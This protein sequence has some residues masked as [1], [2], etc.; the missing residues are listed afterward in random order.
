MVKIVNKPNL[1]AS[2]KYFTARSFCVRLRT[3]LDFTAFTGDQIASSSACILF[4][5]AGVFSQVRYVRRNFYS[6]CGRIYYLVSDALAPA[7]HWLHRTSLWTEC[8]RFY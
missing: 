2:D 7:L 8:E 1:L 5:S 4:L 6:P 3:H